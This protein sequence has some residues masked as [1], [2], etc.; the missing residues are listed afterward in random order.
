[1]HI[2]CVFLYLYLP[3]LFFKNKQITKKKK[4]V[5]RRV[6]ESEEYKFTKSDEHRVLN[7]E[8]CWINKTEEYRVPKSEEPRYTRLW[9]RDTQV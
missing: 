5:E 7:S 3:L 1:M 9:S 8:E 6:N 4:S 2:I